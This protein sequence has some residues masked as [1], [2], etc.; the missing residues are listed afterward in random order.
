MA[1]TKNEKGEFAY[2]RF[3]AVQEAYEQG[4]LG[5]A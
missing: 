2:G 5:A 1:P 4:G 3:S